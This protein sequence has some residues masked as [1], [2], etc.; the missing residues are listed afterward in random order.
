[1][2]AYHGAAAK[3]RS[4]GREVPAAQQDEFRRR[5]AGLTTTILQSEAAR[6]GR[7]APG[8]TDIAAAIEAALA[9]IKTEIG[10]PQ[11]PVDVNVSMNPDSK[12]D[13]N[14]TIRVQGEG[15]V[16]GVSATSSGNIRANPGV[17]LGEFPG[18]TP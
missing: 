10:K 4:R 13:V 3:Y 15:Q 12:S 7:A 9:G 6:E 8:Q 1:M 18:A 14:V 16:T 2:S 11:P 5:A 17:A